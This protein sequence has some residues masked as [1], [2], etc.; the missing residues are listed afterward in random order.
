MPFAPAVLAGEEEKLFRWNP[1]STRAA[2]FMTITLDCSEWMKERCPAVVHIDGTARPQIVDRETNPSFHRVIQKYAEL[3][4]V[5]VVVNT[6]FNMHEEPIVC[7]PSD[8][9]RSWSQGQLDNLAV[10]PFLLGKPPG[11]SIEH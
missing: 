11:R 9:V 10:G 5:P 6:S 2:R 8:A 4:G 1:A 3:S 7:T